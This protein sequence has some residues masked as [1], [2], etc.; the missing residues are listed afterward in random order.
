MKT[1]ASPYLERLDRIEANLEA[2]AY[3]IIAEIQEIILDYVRNDQLYKKGISG[4]GA[5]LVPAYTNYTKAIKRFK[6][7]PTDRVT[8]KDTGDFY[9]DMYVT[10]R[11]GK[12][13]I[14]SSDEKT[15][16]L[17]QKYGKGIML[18]TDENNMIIN[19]K[20]ILPRLIQWMLNELFATT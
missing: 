15:P 7:Q 13:F 19:Q 12:Y 6:G 8:L 18:V 16:M 17:E 5:R 4:F 20:E 1:A 2:Q 14:D 11:D 9:G 10:A 3:K